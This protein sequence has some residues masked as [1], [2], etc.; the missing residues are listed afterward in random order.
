M[1]KDNSTP[2]L[3]GIL[4]EA[5]IEKRIHVHRESNVGML[6]AYVATL[7]KGLPKPLL[8][9]LAGICE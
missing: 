1:A 3:N 5:P 9:R 2:H 8:E 4:L 7:Y 6:M